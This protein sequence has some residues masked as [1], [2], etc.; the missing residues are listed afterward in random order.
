MCETMMERRNYCVLHKSF[1][2]GVH[3]YLND[4]D[5]CGHDKHII[6]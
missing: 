4:D 5:N 2:Q 6:Y 3:L 1:D